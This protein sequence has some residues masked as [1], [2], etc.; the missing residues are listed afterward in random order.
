MDPSSILFDRFGMLRSGWRFAIFTVSVVFVGGLTAALLYGVLTALFPDGPGGTILLTTNGIVSGAVALIVGWLCAKYL[1]NLPFRSL[2]AA[3]T[4]GW[5][6]HFVVGL[7]VGGM[8]FA[9]AAVIG[10]ASGGLSFRTN[11]EGSLPAIASTLLISFVIFFVAAAFEE[12]LLRGYI[13]QT[14]ARS[15][16][17]I[18]AVILTSL[19]FATLH[20]ANPGSTG[21]SWLNTFLAG[22][23]LATAYLKTRD[24]W[25][26]LGV[27]LAWN[28]VQ[29]SV[30]GIEVSGLTEIIKS[31]LMKETDTGPAW[32]TGGV[33]G[34]E[35]GIACTVAL[36]LSVAAIWLL[37]VIKPD[38]ELLAM[39]SHRELIRESGS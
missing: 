17:T 37:P 6:S 26:P 29:G 1:E 32:L 16:L 11:A 4:R 28:W 33:Y 38:A 5:F 9:G 3:L 24:L 21:L 36:I 15:D 2:G 22:I 31:P 39:T 20:N 13:L 14:F 12:A 19:I 7:V 30:F 8:T 27:H 18:F 34:I 35:G 25:F 10:A 23:W